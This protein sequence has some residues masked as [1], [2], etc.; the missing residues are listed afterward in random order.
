MPHQSR[1]GNSSNHY[2]MPRQAWSSNGGPQVTLNGILRVLS[3]PGGLQKKTSTQ[4]L[5][6]RSFIASFDVAFFIMKRVTFH[7]KLSITKV[8]A[9]TPPTR[10]KS[11]RLKSKRWLHLRLTTSTT[12]ATA[13]LMVMPM[14]FSWCGYRSP[15]A[16]T[17]PR[18]SMANWMPVRCFR[19]RKKP[20]M[21]T[22]RSSCLALTRSGTM[23]IAEMNA[24]SGLTPLPMPK[25]RRAK[26]RL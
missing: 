21:C 11:T 26:A 10:Q 18:I 9:S 25:S 13:S 5:S 24:A 6:Y 8:S 20:P 3:A 4:T 7:R 2:E 23:T 17:T 16:T 19:K 22:R 15:V 14:I 1:L 12:A